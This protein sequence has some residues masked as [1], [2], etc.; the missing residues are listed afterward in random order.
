[1]TRDQQRLAGYF[2]IVWKTIHRDLTGLHAQ[3]RQAQ[4]GIRN[5]DIEG[6]EP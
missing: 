4:A 1:M 5:R 6:L 2:E 3:I